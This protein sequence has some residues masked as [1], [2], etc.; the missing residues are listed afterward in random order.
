MTDSHRNLSRPRA[1]SPGASSSA[2]PLRVIALVSLVYDALLGVGLLA[3]RPLLVQ[4]F[5]VPDPVPP[6]HADLNGLFALAIAAGY[7]LPYRDP[8][9]YRGY[10]WVMGPVLKGAGAALFVADFLLRGSPA[11]YL[12]FA[13]ADGTLALV[14]LWGL[15]TTRTR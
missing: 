6:I 4:W 14:T 12:L 13:A 9:R 8:D 3:G 7:W 15:L 2:G 5:G 11:S 10:L 1:A